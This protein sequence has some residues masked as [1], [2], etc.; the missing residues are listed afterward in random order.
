MSTTS[1][2]PRKKIEKDDRRLYHTQALDEYLVISLLAESILMNIN[3][4][5]DIIREKAQKFTCVQR[6]VS[7][8]LLISALDK[9]Y[10]QEM[11]HK[12]K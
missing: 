11:F 8:W 5:S 9:T 3:D 12:A 4:Y 10:K 6:C 2:G 1:E 7:S